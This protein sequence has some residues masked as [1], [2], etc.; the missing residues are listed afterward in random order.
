MALRLASSVAGR[1]EVELFADSLVDLI[2]IDADSRR[3]GNPDP[4]PVALDCDNGN[5]D[6]AADDDLLTSLTSE[7]E[8]V[9]PFHEGRLSC[10]YIAATFGPQC[11][12]SDVV[13]TDKCDPK[14]TTPSSEPGSV[15]TADPARN[16]ESTRI[17]QTR[18]RSE[19]QST[20]QCAVPTRLD[21]DIAHH[22]SCGHPLRNR[23]RTS[24]ESPRLGS[25]LAV[26]TSYACFATLP[27]TRRLP[28]VPSDS[29]SSPQWS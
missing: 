15:K 6:V 3:G 13:T 12:K 2:A 5:A 26:P 9:F 11:L 1:D 24:D 8:H 7:N 22:F 25:R 29:C 4:H 14:R 19:N 27:I 28:C 18:C 20:H 21:W 23:G 10:G 16:P 17:G